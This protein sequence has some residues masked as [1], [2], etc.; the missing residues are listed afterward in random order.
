MNTAE[1]AAYLGRAESSIK[2]AADNKKLTYH[3]NSRGRRDFLAIDLDAYAA[4]RGWAAPK[5]PAEPGPTRQ[6]GQPTKARQLADLLIQMSDIAAEANNLVK[7]MV[8]A[9]AEYAFRLVWDACDA[10]HR[11]LLVAFVD[12]QVKARRKAAG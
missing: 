2:S 4:Q 1:A 9:Q 6:P 12:T 3:L 11:A 10:D 5:Q 7:T 8:P